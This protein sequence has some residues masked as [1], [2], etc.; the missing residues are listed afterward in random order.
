MAEKVYVHLIY[1]FSNLKI[2]RSK[3]VVVLMKSKSTVHG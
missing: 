1:G 3:S 2:F